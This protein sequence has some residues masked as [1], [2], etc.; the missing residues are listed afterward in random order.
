LLCIF[1]P[2]QESNIDVIY[3]LLEWDELISDS[4][5]GRFDRKSTLIDG[6]V[7]LSFWVCG[8]P[9]FG[10]R[11]SVLIQTPPKANRNITTTQLKHKPNRIER[12]RQNPKGE[13][14]EV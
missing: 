9:K 4:E 5:G 2:T 7:L 8:Q 10:W 12:L 1:I 13:A 6:E 11:F 3:G 14:N